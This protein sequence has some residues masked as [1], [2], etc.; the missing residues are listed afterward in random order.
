[1]FYKMNIIIDLNN[2]LRKGTL[3]SLFLSIPKIIWFNFHCLPFHQAI[4]IPF[5]IHYKCRYDCGR[6]RIKLHGRIRPAMVRYGFSI[7]SAKNRNDE[8]YFYVRKGAACV[9]GGSAHIGR[10]SK[11][12]VQKNAMLEIGDNFAISASSTIKCFKHI[13]LGND[14]L[15]AW[16]CLVMDSDGHGIYDKD[17]FRMNPDKDI[18]I[19]NKVW[20]GCGV[21]ILKGA[22]IPKNCVIGAKTIVAGGKFLENTMIVGN[23]PTSRKTIEKWEI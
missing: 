7:D 18:F 19:D 16:D 3:C 9:F 17:G 13:R 1:M 12:V 10:G 23:P 14:I 2:L 15:F 11:I 20:I 5:W 8:T 21:T 4:K 22:N 6:G